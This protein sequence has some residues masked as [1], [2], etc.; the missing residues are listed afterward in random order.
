M[1]SQHSL[2]EKRWHLVMAWIAGRFI[3]ACFSLVKLA[4]VLY[5][6]N[7]GCKRYLVVLVGP[8]P[9]GLIPDTGVKGEAIRNFTGRRGA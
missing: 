2:I 7:S 3:Y 8:G 6:A 4:V 5:W 1:Y 9:R